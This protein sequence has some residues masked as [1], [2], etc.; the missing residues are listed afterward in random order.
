MSPKKEAGSVFI[1]TLIFL[2]LLSAQ[3]LAVKVV[4]MLA[5]KQAL[6]RYTVLKSYDTA[7][8]GLALAPE[9]VT[10]IPALTTDPGK[11]WIYAHLNQ[12][13]KIALTPDDSVFLF[14]TPTA[15]YSAGITQPKGRCLL[16]GTLGPTGNT[17]VYSKI[18]KT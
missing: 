9:I 6:A 5:Q 8:S 12:G 7:W 15:I 18:E 11:T 16:K 2:T 14:K 13:Y 1:A 17:I 10:L 4:L 3:L